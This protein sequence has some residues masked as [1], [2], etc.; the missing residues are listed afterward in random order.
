MFFEEVFSGLF[1]GFHYRLTQGIIYPSDANHPVMDHM[2]CHWWSIKWEYWMKPLCSKST[3]G[4]GVTVGFIWK[5]TPG[6]CSMALVSVEDVCVIYK[7]ESGH[8]HV[9]IP[10]TFMQWCVLG[11]WYTKKLFHFS[12]HGQWLLSGSSVRKGTIKAG[13][14]TP[15][16]KRQ[17]KLIPMGVVTTSP[18]FMATMMNLQKEW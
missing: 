17:W 5:T 8:T 18:T 12:W 14:F 2:S 6:E 7:T 9:W 3:T 15:Y 4:H 13:I 16:G 11:N 10:Y 1:K